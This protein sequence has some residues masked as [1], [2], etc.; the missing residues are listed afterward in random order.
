MQFSGSKTG[1]L[2]AIVLLAMAGSKSFAGMSW[3]VWNGAPTAYASSSPTTD[4]GFSTIYYATSATGYLLD[5]FDGTNIGVTFTGEVTDWSLFNGGEGSFNPFSNTATYLSAGVDTLPPAGNFIAITGFSGMTNT[6]TFSRPVKNILMAIGSMGGTAG[7][8]SYVFNQTPTIIS[9][10]AGNWGNETSPLVVQNGN[11]VYG[12]EGNGVVQFFG[13]IT[14]LSWS[15]PNSEV[16]SLFNVGITVPEPS[17]FSL[18]VLGFGGVMAMR[19]R[20]DAV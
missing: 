18:L 1:L 9:H 14:S 15:I 5:P 2:V 11:E 10:G 16:Y 3:I 6:L 7:P 12:Q 20:R 4:E 19:R 8:G 13:E 17:A